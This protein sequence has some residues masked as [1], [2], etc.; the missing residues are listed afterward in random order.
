MLE[1]GVIG[2]KRVVN[3][4]G[5]LNSGTGGTGGGGLITRIVSAH[6]RLFG[7][8]VIVVVLQFLLM[9]SPIHDVLYRLPLFIIQTIVTAFCGMFGA[10]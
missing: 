3:N 2:M 1:K 9:V 10:V 4:S 6:P 7:A 8:V 5:A